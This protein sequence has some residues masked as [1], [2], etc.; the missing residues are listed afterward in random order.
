MGLAELIVVLTATGLFPSRG[1]L[2]AFLVG[3]FLRVSPSLP[4][5]A[6]APLISSLALDPAGAWIAQDIPLVVL[7]VLAAAE[8]W[9]QRSAEGR[10]ILRTVDP[11]LKP[12]LAA[13]TTL[14]LLGAGE[15]QVAAAALGL[16]PEA[17]A[18]AAA[19]A[20][21]AAPLEA[22][23]LS[24]AG[25]WAAPLASAG[26]V[27]AGTLIRRAVFDFFADADPDDAVGI[28]RLLHG[29][30]SLWVVF[31]VLMLFLVPALVVICA[32]LLIGLM[33]IVEAR[34]RRA[35]AAAHAPC[36]SCGSSVHAAALGCPSC[37]A[38][39]ASPRTLTL[40]GVGEA[41]AD[42][43]SQRRALL[44]SRRC[45]RCATALPSARPSQRCG[46]CGLVTFETDEARAELDAIVRRR[47]P[48]YLVGAGIV[49]LVPVAGA[50][51]ALVAFRVGL[52]G[53]YRR[54]TP[55]ARALAARWGARLLTLVLLGVHWVPPLGLLCLPAIGFVQWTVARQAFMG[56]PFEP[57]SDEATALE[58]AVARHAPK[59]AG[60][61]I[62]TGLVVA[63]AAGVAGVAYALG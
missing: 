23:G 36:A 1:F 26:L 50:I 12:A 55:G 42:R 13:A 60:L 49:G 52:T 41:A 2:P 32:G 29:V 51:A 4:W 22:M 44:A 24:G 37:H 31:G 62:A 10:E 30:E 61:R 20:A 15:G 56:A 7:G 33:A 14:G 19:S 28:Q 38:E 58:D 54:Y 5:L 40:F 35:E 6:N 27:F 21:A 63:I 3:L 39:Q 48:A 53:P 34:S 25:E 46:R 59:L 11:Y 9:A 17:A 45:P 47:L 43:A 8:A 18:G 16:G 57:A